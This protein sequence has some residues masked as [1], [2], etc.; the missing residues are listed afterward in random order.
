MPTQYLHCVFVTSAIAAICCASLFAT[1]KSLYR[2]ECIEANMGSS[3][4]IVRPAAIACIVTATL[5]LLSN[6]AVL[7]TSQRKRARS[8]AAA[9]VSK[10]QAMYFFAASL[11]RI[12]LRLI[13]ISAVAVCP[14]N[15]DDETYIGA[16]T[17]MWDCTVFLIG[18]PTVVSD[19]DG[20]LSTSRRRCAYLV[21]A[22][23]LLID[24]VSSYINGN[25]MAS[26]VTVSV[27]IFDI[28]LDNSITSSITSQAIIVCHFLS[29]S[30]RSRSGRGW[31]YPSL[32]FEL[33]ERGSAAISALRSTRSSGSLDGRSTAAKSTTG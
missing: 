31:M 14:S 32:R 26:P 2:S 1:L 23:C 7:F 19:M 6:A 3:G 8:V 18:V 15:A 17:I 10:W 4:N 9:I 5:S 11:E 12:I 20:D 13:V 21:L 27:G 28:F 25:T 33:D 29:V 22:L 30:C 16:A 24:A